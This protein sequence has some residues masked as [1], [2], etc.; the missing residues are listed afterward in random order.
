M[1]AVGRVTWLSV[2]IALAVAMHGSIAHAQETESKNE[3]TSS[4][5]QTERGRDT[6]D[7]KGMQGREGMEDQRGMAGM[8][9]K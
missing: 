2:L 9:M 3:A 1:N 5:Q 7:Q 4:D 8:T 6:G